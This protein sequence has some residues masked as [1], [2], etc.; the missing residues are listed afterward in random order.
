MPGS[1]RT[2]QSDPSSDPIDDTLIRRE[3]G[4]G[5]AEHA[6]ANA[7]FLE[8][9]LAW[10]ATPAARAHARGQLKFHHLPSNSHDVDDVLNEARERVWRRSLG[11]PITAE[12]PG[13][14][15]AQVIT[16]IV[17]RIIR[18]DIELDPLTDHAEPLPDTAHSPGSSPVIDTVDA[19][20]IRIETCGAPHWVR[21]GALT[22][23]T[24]V[25]EPDCDVRDVPQPQSHTSNAHYWSALWFAGR[26]TD[27]FPGTGKDHPRLRKARNRAI[28]IVRGLIDRVSLEERGAR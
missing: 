9:S 24:A 17:R 15:C 13:A 25:S 23:V 26:R 2:L 27:C 19:L 10:F 12:R 4:T 1:Q 6:D 11:A 20:R 28:E 22:F 8:E 7:R 14:Y 5:L 3:G 21:S 18:S 16:N